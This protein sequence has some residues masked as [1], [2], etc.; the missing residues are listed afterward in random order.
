MSRDEIGKPLDAC[1]RPHRKGDGV[2]EKLLRI[3]GFVRR[4]AMMILESFCQG[5]CNNA[6]IAVIMIRIF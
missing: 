1:G 5:Q 2:T 3:C 6:K 4:Y